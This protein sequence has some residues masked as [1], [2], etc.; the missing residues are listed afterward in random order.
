MEQKILITKTAE[1]ENP[2]ITKLIK[3]YLTVKEQLEHLE[4]VRIDLLD[5]I[6]SFGYKT[7]G[8]ERENIK[9]TITPRKMVKKIDYETTLMNQE[10][11]KQFKKE[12]IS[13][14]WDDEKIIETLKDNVVYI[15]ELSKPRATITK[16]NKGE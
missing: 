9:L 12:K 6:H 2:K 5:E 13:M 14:V 7:I 11:I 10:D 4:E 1:K 16:I 8:Y 15:E 3:Q